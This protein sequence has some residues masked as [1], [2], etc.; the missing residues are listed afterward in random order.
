MSNQYSL[1][2]WLIQIPPSTKNI[3]HNLSVYHPTGCYKICA[4]TIQITSTCATRIPLIND[5]DNRLCVIQVD[6]QGKLIPAYSQIAL[7]PSDRAL[8]KMY[9]LGNQNFES[10]KFFILCST[11]LP[12]NI[13]PEIICKAVQDVVEVNNPKLHSTAIFPGYTAASKVP[14]KGQHLPM[15]I[16]IATQDLSKPNEKIMYNFLEGVYHQTF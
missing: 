15:L 16:H 1:G 12:L 13:P 9:L 3:F 8:T 7:D 11:I 6:T 14:K 5:D 10:K 2:L 4:A